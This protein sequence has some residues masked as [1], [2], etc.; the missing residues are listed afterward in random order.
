ML[1]VA[2]FLRGTED[3]IIALKYVE[4]MKE[5]SGEDLTVDRLVDDLHISIRM[6][7]GKEYTVSVRQQYIEGDWRVKQDGVEQAMIAIFD[8]WR[9][10]LTGKSS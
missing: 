3:E 10:I 4:S 9:H 6:V 2:D 8:R 5:P 1:F 7:S